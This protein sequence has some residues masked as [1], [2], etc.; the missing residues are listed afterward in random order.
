MRQSSVADRK[1]WITI[2]LA[3][4]FSVLAYG[5]VCYLTLHNPQRRPPSPHLATLSPVLSGLA[6]L[7]LV[8]SVCWLQSKTQRR[9]SGVGGDLMTPTQFQTESIVALA[10]A[11]MCAIFGL[12][13]FF[14]GG[15]WQGFVPF[16]LGTLA[17]DLAFILPKGIRYWA[18]WEVA[19]QPRDPSPFE[20]L[21]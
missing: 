17:I 1:T 9:M 8:A 5:L 15:T 11:E 19:Q 12:L 16:A 3:M 2:V 13:L 4:A 7:A 20:E 14:L 6:I 21:K 10:F 18:A